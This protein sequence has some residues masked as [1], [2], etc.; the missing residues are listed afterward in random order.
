MTPEDGVRCYEF[1]R[2][3]GPACALACAASTVWRNYF[4]PME[5]DG[6]RGQRRERQLNNLRDLQA[7]LGGG[8]LEVRNGYAS[9]APAAV[10]RVEGLA[11]EDKDRLR[12]AVRVGVQWDAEAMYRAL[13]I[14]RN[15][16]LRVKIVHYS[17]RAPWMPAYRQLVAAFAAGAE[18]GVLPDFDEE[19]EG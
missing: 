6:P 1:D 14:Y 5:L 2:T 13:D 7:L 19:E 17:D 15:S 12:R 10:G 8:L 16:G 18:A 3:Q 9:P 4:V 11:E